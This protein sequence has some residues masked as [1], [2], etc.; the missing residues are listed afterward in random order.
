MAPSPPPPKPVPNNRNEVQVFFG[1][2]R[3]YQNNK[4]PRETFS[5]LRNPNP[6]LTLGTVNVSIPKNHK[7]GNLE[8]PDVFTVNTSLDSDR[9]LVLKSLD[10]LEPGPFWKNLQNRVHGSKKKE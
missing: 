3:Q 1:A 7:F 9:F 5:E 10:R 6:Q 4:P 8:L 2:D